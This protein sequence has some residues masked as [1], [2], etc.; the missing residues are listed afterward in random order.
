M[1][2]IRAIAAAPEEQALPFAVQ[3]KPGT[4]RGAGLPAS[5]VRGNMKSCH[6]RRGRRPMDT[7]R[8]SLLL[9]SGDA[10]NTPGLREFDAIYPPML[11]RF[12]RT[13][14]LDHSAAEDVVSQCVSAVHRHIG[15]FEYDPSRARFESWLRTLVNNQVRDGLRNRQ[16]HQGE[17]RDFDLP[18]ILQTSDRGTRGARSLPGAGHDRQ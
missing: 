13:R 1:M 7:T 10:G 8:S 4:Q 14:G 5:P 6:R 11:Y 9:R 2:W 3:V 17:T 12:A 16:D 15:G 18:A